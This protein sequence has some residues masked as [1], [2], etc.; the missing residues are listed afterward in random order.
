MLISKI[1]AEKN[2]QRS[3][4]YIAITIVLLAAAPSFLSEA[5]IITMITLLMYTTLTLSWTLFSGP[6]KYVSL[7]TAGLFGV[8][9]YS[10]A[11]LRESL[12]IEVIVLIGGALAFALAL[13]IGVLTLRLKGVYF[14]LFTFGV[15][16]LVRNSTHWWETHVTG[17]VGRHVD[18]A[19]NSVVYLLALIIFSLTLITAT[20]RGSVR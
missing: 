11:V 18:G 20:S 14:I 8:G 10:S 15:T 16:A 12:P 19:S 5:N 2:E 17:T 4:A 13:A 3:L 6:T 7:A 1:R 9:V